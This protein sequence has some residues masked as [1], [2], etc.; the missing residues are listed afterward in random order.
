MG[1]PKIFETDK[2]FFQNF[3]FWGGGT[4]KIFRIDDLFFCFYVS[5]KIRWE[6]PFFHFFLPVKIEQ[7]I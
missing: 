4:P 6:M 1:A 5:P 2:L 3:P 7:F